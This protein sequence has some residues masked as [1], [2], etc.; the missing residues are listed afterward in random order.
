MIVD[1]QKIIQ[2]KR[3][4][5]VLEQ[6]YNLN[7]ERKIEIESVVDGIVGHINFTK[8]PF[9]DIVSIVEK[10]G[11]VVESRKMD[12]ETTGYLFIG[13]NVRYIWVNTDFKNPNNDDDVVFKKSRFITAHEYGHYKL[14]N[15]S[16]AHRDTYHRT[17]PQELEADYFARSILM[18]LKYFNACYNAVKEYN[19]NDSYIIDI[20]TRFFSVTKDKVSKRIADLSEL[21]ELLG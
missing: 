3:G 19:S 7:K 4:G 12:I 16:S 17:E 15:V 10:E 6:V 1:L 14:H 11:F 20:L 2:K 13:D 9:I 8:N 21:G 18:P 5:V